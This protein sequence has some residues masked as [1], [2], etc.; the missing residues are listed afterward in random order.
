MLMHIFVSR[1]MDV[2]CAKCLA[3][4]GLATVC[5]LRTRVLFSVGFIRLSRKFDA[6]YDT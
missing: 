6:F 1:A 2:N 4:S 3:W 5:V